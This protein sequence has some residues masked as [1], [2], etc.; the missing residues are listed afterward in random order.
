MHPLFNTNLQELSDDELHKKHGEL[1]KRMLQAN[2]MGYSDVNYQFQAI[3]QHFIDEI[4]RRDREKLNK[5]N[6][7]NDDFKDYIDIG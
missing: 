1:L 6:K 5:L 2:R 4:Q 3:V 7:D